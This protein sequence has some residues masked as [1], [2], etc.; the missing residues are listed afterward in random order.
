[1]QAAAQDPGQHEQC[2]RNR[3]Q[4]PQHQAER[5]EEMGIGVLFVGHECSPDAGLKRAAL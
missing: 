2:D 5:I 3:D 1:L 4:D